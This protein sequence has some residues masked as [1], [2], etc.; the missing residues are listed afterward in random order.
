M[1]APGA[2]PP[3]S[4]PIA[5]LQNNTAKWWWADPGLRKLALG[6]ACGFAVTVNNGAW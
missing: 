1:P 6:I 3:S 2:P 4:L 5:H